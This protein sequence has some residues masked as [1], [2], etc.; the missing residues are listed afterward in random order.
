MVSGVGF[1]PTPTFTDQKE[2][3][4]KNN[5]LVNKSQNTYKKIMASEQIMSEAIA[6]AVAEATR[7]ALQTMAEAQVEG[8]HN[9][10]GP[11]VGSPTTKQPMFDWN[12]QDKY[13]VL[14]TF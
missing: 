13:S 14:K 4:V 2:S 7:I 8:T 11:K 10:S 12:A 5:N 1:K 3:G 9:E 6:R